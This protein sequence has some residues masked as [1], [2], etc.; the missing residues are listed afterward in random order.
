MDTVDGRL[1]ELYVTGDTRPDE[2]VPYLAGGD[3]GVGWVNDMRRISCSSSSGDWLIYAEPINEVAILAI[4]HELSLDRLAPTLADLG[5]MSVPE[6]LNDPNSSYGFN[7][8]VV[9]EEWRRQLSRAY[10]TGRT[11]KPSRA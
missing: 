4:R 11:Y 3:G 6:A 5:A 1:E 10:S 2:Y 8:H 7:P 9:S